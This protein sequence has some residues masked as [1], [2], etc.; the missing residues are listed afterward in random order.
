MGNVVTVGKFEGI[1][2]KGFFIQLKKHIIANNK[3]SVLIEFG[4]ISGKD[5][6]NF[7]YYT[8]DKTSSYFWEVF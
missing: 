8:C 7:Y 1:G 4:K 2:C 5:K 3:S 6:K